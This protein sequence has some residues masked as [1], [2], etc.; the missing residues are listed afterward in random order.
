MD[1]TWFLNPFQVLEFA[2]GTIIALIFG[3]YFLYAYIKFR[4]SNRKRK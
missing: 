4:W 1:I 2:I 3:S